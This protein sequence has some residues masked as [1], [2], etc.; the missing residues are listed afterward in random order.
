MDTGY[1]F[2][3]DGVLTDT[4][5]YHFRSWLKLAQE[6]HWSFTRE[7]NERLRGVPR[8]QSLQIILDINQVSFSN[9]E[10]EQLA[11]HKNAYYTDLIREVTPS[12]LLPGVEALLHEARANGIHLGLGSASKNAK[13]VCQRLGILSLLDAVGDGYSVV[14]G[15]PAPDLFVWV[16]G[17]LGLN[18]TQCIVFEDAEAGIEAALG[19]GF[20]AVGIGPKERVGKAHRVRKNLDGAKIDEFKLPLR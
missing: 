4:A 9:A 17:R 7:D 20:W 12:D 6:N 10:K 16:A 19:G 15:K 1:I 18:P 11:A 2:D 13:D 3:L 14:R 8:L 5:E